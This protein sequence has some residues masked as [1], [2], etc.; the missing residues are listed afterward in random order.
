MKFTLTF[1]SL[2]LK[3]LILFAPLLSFMIFAIVALSLLVGRIEKWA[4][5]DA[6]YWGFITALT[7]GYGDIKPTKKSSRIFSIFIAACGIIMSGILVALSVEA[8]SR[9]YQE[10]LILP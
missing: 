10:Y 5:F 4:H 9:T 2:L 1:L 8:A 6:I 7:V 3:G